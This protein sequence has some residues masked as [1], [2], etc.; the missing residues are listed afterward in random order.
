MEVYVEI[1]GR[2]Y[3][4]VHGSKHG[5]RSNSIRKL[6]EISVWKLVEVTGSHWKLNGSSR[7]KSEGKLVESKWK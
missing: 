5:S 3:G 7:W 6:V 2:V 1:G 4:E